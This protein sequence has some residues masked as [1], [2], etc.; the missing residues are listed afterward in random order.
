MKKSQFIFGALA[1]GALALTSCNDDDNKSSAG[2]AGTYS[3]TEVNTETQTDFNQDGTSSTNQKQETS[4]YNSGRITLNT[5][6]TLTYVIT[7]VLIGTSDGSVGCKNEF[8]A[9]GQWQTQTGNDENAVISAVYTD[10]NG[11]NKVISLTKI[12]SELT[13]VDDNILS[14]YPDRNSSG[15]PYYRSGSVEY[16]FRK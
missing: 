16:V 13:L 8:Q 11:D 7:G 6:G 5:D 10:Q 14:S 4:C 3:L 12:G 2:V 9:S 1:L 15:E